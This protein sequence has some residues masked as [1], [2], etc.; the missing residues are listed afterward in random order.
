M[1]WFNYTPM[2]DMLTES[3]TVSFL[4]DE[5][6]ILTDLGDVNSIIKFPCVYVLSSLGDFCMELSLSNDYGIGCSE[7]LADNNLL[8]GILNMGLFLPSC[9]VNDT[10]AI[11]VCSTWAFLVNIICKVVCFITDN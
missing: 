7:L 9:L 3:H 8:E 4:S 2:C 11:E 1:E 5:L 6:G 10:V